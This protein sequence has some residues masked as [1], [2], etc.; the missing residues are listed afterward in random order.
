MA[1]GENIKTYF[2]GS[3]HDGDK[4]ILRAA[5]HGAWLGSSVFDG[6]RFFEGVTPDLLLHCE[7][8]NNSARAMM[9][10][11]VVSP[12]EMVGIIKEGLGSFDKS[13]SV[14]I[15][16][17]YW[18]LDGSESLVLPKENSTA[19]SICLEQIP[20]AAATASATLSRTKF[21][22]PVLED[23]VVNAKA[24]CLYPNNARMLAEA[25]SKGFTNAL[26]AD[27]AGNVAET[28]TANIFMVKDGEVFTPI[29]NGTFLAGITR[30]RH[31]QNLREYGKKVSETVL[32]FR[33]FE[34]A[35]EVFMTGNMTKIMPVTAFEDKN[36]QVGSVA[37]LAREL[38]W[39]WASSQTL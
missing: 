7:R 25:R 16:P 5:D 32:T 28:A 14:Y 2:N 26:V 29:P 23:N 38:Y 30:A 22:R 3:W 11:P 37:K 19:F 24:G 35:E 17:M 36:Y 21:R 8:V 39:D 4:Y 18:A 33:D 15:R 12:E 31:I 20:M 34:E 13:T 27:A 1:S 9:L 6:A 10:D